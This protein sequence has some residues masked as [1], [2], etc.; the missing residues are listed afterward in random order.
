MFKTRRDMDWIG[1]AHLWIYIERFVISETNQPF[2]DSSTCNLALRLLALFLYWCNFWADLC[3]TFCDQGSQQLLARYCVDVETINPVFW[4]VPRN[5][6]A[7]FRPQSEQDEV[8]AEKNA[9]VRHPVC[10]AQPPAC[11]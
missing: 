10:H 3:G 5:L 11:R 1:A 7:D 8:D 4:L 6:Q 2:S 9:S